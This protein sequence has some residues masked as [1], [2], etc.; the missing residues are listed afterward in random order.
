MEAE[1]RPFL[2][3]AFTAPEAVADE[4][5]RIAA[6]LAEEGYDFVHIRKPGW[7]AGQTAALIG[8]IPEPLHCR[9]RLHDHFRLA[10]KYHLAGVHLNS[11][12]PV[13]PEAVRTTKS[14]HTVEEIAECGDCDY[15]TLSPVFDSISKEGYKAGIAPDAL[16][17]VKPK[18]PVVALGG[19]RPELFCVI[20]E[21]GFA[22]AALLGYLWPETKK[23]TDDATV[24]NQH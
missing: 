18:V 4:A 24:H 21:R 1:K 2:K 11:R 15:V 5:A 14:C 19:V 12:N 9:L 20:R 23:Q 16:L 3:I 10:K 22:G 7:T 6:L 17:K 13:A 8:Q